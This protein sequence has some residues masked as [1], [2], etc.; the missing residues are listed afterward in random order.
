MIHALPTFARLGLLVMVASFLGACKTATEAEPAY[1]L[2]Q[3]CYSVFSEYNQRFLVA[4]ND[5][6]YSFSGDG[7]AEAEKFFLKPT[8][9][10]SFLLYDSEGSYLTN[11]FIHV[12]RTTEST[13]GSEWRIN[14]MDR[15][16]DK[17]PL[18]SKYTL[19]ANRGNL[20][21]L[22]GLT[23][24][25]L[26]HS[27]A[28]PNSGHIDAETA[29]FDLI[30]QPQESCK[31]FPEAALDA[32]VSPEFYEPKDPSKPVVGFADL[33]TH[34]GFPKAMGSVVMSGGIFHP[35][36]IE[37]ALHDCKKLHGTNGAYDLLES[38]HV[39]DGQSGHATAGYPEF[40]YWPNR[41]TNTHVQAY[42]RW[43]ERAY[44]SGMRIN[45][46]LVTGNPTFCQLN[47]TLH[48]GMGEGDCDSTSAMELQSNYIYDLQDYVDAQ[49][50]G[51]GKGWLRVVTS[52]QQAREVISQNKL[53]VVLGTEYGTL[54][55][56]RS[57]AAFCT[58]E[59]I[60]RE[61]DKIHELGIRSVFPIHRFD[62]EFGGT[63]PQG[64]SGGAFMHLTSKMNTGNINHIMDLLNPTKL[65]FKPIGG[66][67]WDLQDCP[68]GIHGTGGI[69]SMREFMEKD[70]GFLRDAAASIPAAGPMV[71]GAMDILFFNKLD[72]IPEYTEYNHGGHACNVRPLQA[73]GKY[74][75]NRLID[76][77]MILE[78][79]HLSYNTL[80]ETLD[81]L[82][83]RQYSGFISSHGWLENG[84][85]IRARIF[86]LGGIMTPFNSTPTNISNH[87]KSY[88]PE[89]QQYEHAIGIGIGSDVQG[90]TSQAKGDDGFSI[91]Y[92]FTS[93]DGMVTFTEP[94]TGNRAFN[95]NEEGIAHYGLLAEWV[96]N[97]RQV[98]ARDQANVMD[99]FMN[100]AEAYLQM[101]ERAEASRV[102]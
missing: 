44:L 6:R 77:G 43:I 95:F 86:R 65:L 10:G 73:K 62:N 25:V 57:G 23:G 9:L 41:S 12:R 30:E 79:D 2:A 64:G 98:D 70:F 39:G 20:R 74:L 1:S 88:R 38:Q 4:K 40:T 59:Y 29:A 54:F 89:M 78:I 21:L 80:M 92:P 82:E 11:E 5:S 67:Y 35:L 37:H 69:T 75:I 97:L 27:I 81:V 47:S 85:D 90:V 76:K 63:K 15:F 102:H 26:R 93:V 68:E 51:P 96:E 55:D 19:V 84:E 24:I 13:M 17:E 33:H 94:A 101:W 46:T 66:N 50:G 18:D 60:D 87:I 61:L 56:C 49:A 14:H 48:L 22:N 52:P 72:P 31:T 58:E 8:G 42:Y 100:S 32:I 7:P 3:G 99:I 34:I 53:A 16:V 83:Q 45:V 91:S 28:S 36:G 71:A